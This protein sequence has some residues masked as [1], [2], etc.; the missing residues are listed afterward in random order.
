MLITH[1]GAE[2]SDNDVSLYKWFEMKSKD[3][4]TKIESYIINTDC[5]EKNLDTTRQRDKSY[6]N[7]FEDLD[8]MRKPERS[9]S[10]A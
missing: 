6:N 9:Q 3:D 2:N 7:S 8:P 1:H 5:T 4:E 10:L